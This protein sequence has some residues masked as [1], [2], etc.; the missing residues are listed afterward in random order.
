MRCRT[1][2]AEP[3]RT[4]RAVVESTSAR[5]SPAAVASSSRFWCDQNM[6]TRPKLQRFP[7]AARLTLAELGAHLA[8]RIFA[9]ELA[10]VEP[11][12]GPHLRQDVD[13]RKRLA[14]HRAAMPPERQTIG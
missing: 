12:E 9:E 7:S 2:T 13:R 1:S 5:P 6:R 14:R 11:V 10:R 8:A 4:P 3:A